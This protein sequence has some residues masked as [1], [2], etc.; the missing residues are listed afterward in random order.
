MGDGVGQDRPVGLKI[1]IVA[2][3]NPYTNDPD[4]G[5]RLQVLLD[6][7]PRPDVQVEVFDR[8]IGSQEPAQITLY[9]TNA[10]GIA[11]FSLSA[12]REYMVDNVA[13][14]ALQPASEGDPVW[15]SL[16]A[17]LTF[18]VPKN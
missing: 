14:V 6:G 16:W 18:A 3:R 9:R 8:P 5:M 2:L 12:G 11:Q 4:D 10:N 7:Q 15:R 1:E 17:H 13:L